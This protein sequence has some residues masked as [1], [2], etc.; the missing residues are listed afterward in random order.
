MSATNSGDTAWLL[1]STALVLVMLPGLA[2]FYG[3]LVR[4]KNVLSTFMHSFMALG[5]VTVQ[6]VLFGYS[7]AFGPD[8]GGVIGG[9]DHAFLRGVGFEPRP[10]STVPHL[11]FM[12]Y[13]L[14]FAII[15]PALISGAFAERVKMS[16][17]AIFTVLWTT[18][19]YDPL[20]HWFWA[21]GGWLGKLGAV[22]FAGGV[23]V[24]IS[25]GFAALVFALVIGARVGYPREKHVPHNLTMTLLGAG[26]LWFGWFG[27]NGGSAMSSGGLAA[28][29]LTNSQIAAAAGALVWLVIDLV[30]YGKG[31]ALG[32]ASGLVAGLATVTPAAGFVGPMS[33]MAIGAAAGAACYCAVTV[34]SR[35]GYDDTLDA[36]GVHGVGG[37]LGTVLT[38]VFAAKIWNAAGADGLIHG[39]TGFFLKQLAAAATGGAYAV[40]GTWVLLKIVDKAVGL[41]V[42]EEQEREGLDFHL[43][44]EEGY[45][46]GAGSGGHT[47]SAAIRPKVFAEPRH[48]TAQRDFVGWGKDIQG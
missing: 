35:L 31:S 14:M 19:I 47:D 42:S 26:L 20:A 25:S 24:H 46:I 11:L 32:F 43:H 1:V 2:L 15:T 41:R 22:D 27:F 16:S 23:V 30:R 9:L 37:V 5:L 45:A 21:D 48:V 39:G 34:K 44:G 28:L 13:Q 36:F 38:G 29:A 8:H 4:T 17:Y 10:G 18:L 3:G 40:A 7:L 33:A 6:W 12:S